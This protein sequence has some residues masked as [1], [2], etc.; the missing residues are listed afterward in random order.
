MN[1]A[2]VRMFLGIDNSD[3]MK[4]SKAE[5]AKLGYQ[6]VF[7]WVIR[8][9]YRPGRWKQGGSMNVLTCLTCL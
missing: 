8:G 4:A 2:R 5:W 1:D 6:K 3:E 7:R 9:D